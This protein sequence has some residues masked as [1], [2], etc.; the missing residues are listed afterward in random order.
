MIMVKAGKPVD[1]M[2]HQLLPLLEKGDLLIDGGNSWF[3]DTIR[4]AKAVEEK[5]ILYLGAGV[6]GGEEGAL[7][8][9][10][11]MPGGHREAYEAAG[12]SCATFPRRS[13]ASPAAPTSGLT[14]PAIT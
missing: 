4:R 8:G 5:G 9:P 3:A 14:G 12:G 1:E 7:K 2:I 10:S 6:S 13:T 11:I